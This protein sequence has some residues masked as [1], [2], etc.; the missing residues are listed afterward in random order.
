MAKSKKLRLFHAT[1]VEN[2]DSILA[3]GL[4]VKWDGVYLTDSAESAA[5]WMGFRFAAMGIY[6]FAVIEVEV[7]SRGLIEGSDHSPMMHTL[8]GAG[9]SILSP[10]PI[11]P[12][13][14]RE[15]HYFEKA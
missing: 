13:A 4:L 15:V 2:V 7:S 1:A 5:R 3:H 11:P 14:I 8:F 10:K 6:K 9:K 12:S